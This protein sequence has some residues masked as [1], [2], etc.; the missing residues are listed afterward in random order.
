MGLLPR[1]NFIWRGW[2]ADQKDHLTQDPLARLGQEFLSP[3]Q[4]ARSLNHDELCSPTTLAKRPTRGT[5][6]HSRVAHKLLSEV[7]PQGVAPQGVALHVAF[8]GMLRMPTV[9]ILRKP[10]NLAMTGARLDSWAAY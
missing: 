4:L 9:L 5:L 3:T 6:I 1:L 10:S 7:A 2:P 8:C